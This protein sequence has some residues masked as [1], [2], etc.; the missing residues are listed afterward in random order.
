[1]R[2]V[3]NVQVRWDPD[4]R[5]PEPYERG[6]PMRLDDERA[7]VA[8]QMALRETPGIVAAEFAGTSPMTF[9]VVVDDKPLEDERREALRLN[10]GALHDSSITFRVAWGQDGGIKVALASVRLEVA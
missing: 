9:V 10:V 7:V 5:V 1:M 6:V 3:V 8:I 2:T 4:K